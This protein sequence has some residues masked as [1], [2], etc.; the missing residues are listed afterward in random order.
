MSP[1]SSS[2]G[3]RHLQERRKV[4]TIQLILT[5][6]IIIRVKAGMAEEYYRGG[7]GGE[8]VRTSLRLSYDCPC[9]CYIN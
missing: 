4:R 8:N 7:Q 6:F 3:R 9:S 2:S 5:L 1:S